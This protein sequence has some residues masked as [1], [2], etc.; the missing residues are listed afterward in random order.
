MGFTAASGFLRDLLIAQGVPAD[1]I[2]LVPNAISP[3]FLAHCKH[4]GF[5]RPG[6]T[7]RILSI[8]R[9]IGWKGQDILLRALARLR[10]MRPEVP[11]HVTFVYGREARE[12]AAVKDLAQVLDLA[13]AVTFVPFV[14]VRGTPEVL[15]EFDLFVLPST[16]SRDAV[17]RTET[18]GVAILEAM[19]AGLPVIGT[20]AGGIPEVI[21][22]PDTQARIVPHGQ[23]EP[24]AEAM[25]AMI[26]AP[27]AVFIPARARAEACTSRFA[28]GVRLRA[29]AAAQ[30]RVDAPRKR[31]VHF[32]ALTR[33][34]AAGASVN[35]HRALLRRGY[36]SVFVTRARD[37]ATG[38]EELPG[39]VM[40]APDV[41]VGFE[42]LQA[43]WRP[44]FTIFS[45]DEESISDAALRKVVAGADLINLTWSARFLSAGNVAMLSRLGVP[46]VITLR[47]MQ[48][49]TG[50]C[51]FFHGCDGWQG[52][53]ADCPQLPVDPDTGYAALTFRA[54]ALAWN[55]AAITFAA[56]S[57]H[58]LDVLSR[59]PLATPERCIKLPNH[60]D[61]TAFH[62]D[63]TPLQG[64]EALPPGVRI[65]YLPSFGSR[66]KGHTELMAA[67]RRLH[68]R[69]PDLAL[70]LVMASDA[71]AV[72]EPVPF[73][74]HRIPRLE[75]TDALRQFYNAMD[76]VAVP[77]LEETFSNT[78][79]EALACGTPVA[80]FATGVLPEVLADGRLGACAPLGCVDALSAAIEDLATRR[81]DRDAVARAV[82]DAYGM[83]ARMDAYEAAFARLMAR[84]PAP[85]TPDATA[86]A[87][88]ADL[89]AQRAA[90][91]AT[92]LRARLEQ[93]AT[94]KIG[95]LRRVTRWLR[96]K[97]R[98]LRRRFNRP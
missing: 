43:P 14:D 5:W 46:V 37:D 20:D 64:L 7:L 67:L 22:P 80:G 89:T 38:I 41:S 47:D 90:L 44:G 66:I 96:E 85:A 33:G 55:H 26:D 56:L 31:I 13:D 57:D 30:A 58:S 88:L 34:G 2:T 68:A 6:R 78:C 28:P 9:L 98:R 84:P 63:P 19:A 15:A 49:I 45:L 12:L 29:L 95:G 61:A 54:R 36:D 17:P 60:V 11:V 93:L 39:V 76:I 97:G 70:V 53:C 59:S 94:A 24:L 62:P 51:H 35:V 79:L 48:M 75:G 32:C 18:F 10:E 40:L 8:G 72:T 74:V 81:F 1:R 3:A 4:D 16:L 91:G 92:A 77:S 83:E 87:A 42:H 73:V 86:L 23:P 82:A 50:G 71:P 27:E 69:R 25:A 52:G 21:G 65:G